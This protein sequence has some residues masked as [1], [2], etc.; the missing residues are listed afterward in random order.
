MGEDVENILLKL[1]QAADYDVEK[2]QK[3][4][5]YVDEI[6]KIA[7]KTENPSITRDV[8]G[9]GV[10]QALLKILEGSVANVPPQGGRKHPHQEFIQ[11]DTKDVLFICG[12]A[13]DGI[14]EV[15]KR[16]IGEKVIGFNSDISHNEEKRSEILKKIEPEDFLKYGLIPEFIGRLPVV[17]TLQELSKDAL[18]RIIKE[19][20]NALLKQYKKL[21]EID[22]VELDVENGA[23]EAVAD[24]AVMKNTGA[25]GLRSIFENVMRDVMYEVPSRDDVKKCIITKDTVENDMPPTLVFADTAAAS[26][27]T[28]DETA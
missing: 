10:Q 4:I 8:S 19:P 15:I 11:F 23:I 18:I 17:V 20:K 25:R 9:E 6:D 16:R 2:A 7:R 27:K 5:V 22:G 1:L 12:G 13:F 24:K 28:A 14:N 26:R 21:F 3:G